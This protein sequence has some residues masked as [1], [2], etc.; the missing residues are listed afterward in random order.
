VTGGQGGPTAD[1]AGRE[2]GAGA[3]QPAAATS[4]APAPCR[5]RA[6]RKEGEVGSASDSGFFPV[7]NV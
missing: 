1:A 5:T 7:S 6:A 2:L 4:A 3:A